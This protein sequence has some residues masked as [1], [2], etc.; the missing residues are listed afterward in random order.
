M[1][2]MIH[3]HYIQP[4]NDKLKKNSIRSVTSSESNT[5]KNYNLNE[6]SLNNSTIDSSMS[7]DINLNK[8]I[9]NNLKSSFNSFNIP[10]SHSHHNNM[11]SGN[12]L[13]NDHKSYKEVYGD[14]D[15]YDISI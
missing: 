5:S 13:S 12:L 2:Y 9:N 11:T 1:N 14:F 4:Q 7:N 3:K 8:S 10:K 15:I 6:N